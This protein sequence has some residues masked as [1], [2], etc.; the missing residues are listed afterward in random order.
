MADT[1]Q[2]ITG[3]TWGEGVA[4]TSWLYMSKCGQLSGWS[5]QPCHGRQNDKMLSVGVLV[6]HLMACCHGCGPSPVAI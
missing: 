6:S 5:A 2:H 4:E 3:S 1:V